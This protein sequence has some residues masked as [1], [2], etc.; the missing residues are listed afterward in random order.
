MDFKNEMK[1]EFRNERTWVGME[2]AKG[3][4]EMYNWI[5][6]GKMETTEKNKYLKCNSRKLSLKEELIIYWKL[7]LHDPGKIY[8]EWSHECIA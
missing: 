8:P 2:D 5:H 7:N 3:N 1:I 4:F 6:A